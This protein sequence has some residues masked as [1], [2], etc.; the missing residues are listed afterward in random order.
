MKFKTADDERATF[1]RRTATR[2]EIARRSHAKRFQM[3]STQPQLPVRLLHH[4]QPS[5]SRAKRQCRQRSEMQNG[6]AKSQISRLEVDPFQNTLETQPG[7]A[8]FR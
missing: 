5:E 6:H 8:K 4:R 1:L 2:G 3:V 7:S